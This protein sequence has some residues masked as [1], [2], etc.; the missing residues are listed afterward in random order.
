MVFTQQFRYDVIL[1]ESA[2]FSE[3]AAFVDRARAAGATAD[4]PVQAVPVAQDDSIIDYLSI[5]LDAHTA[6]SGGDAIV[7]VHINV[8]RQLRDLLDQ[9]RTSEGDAIAS[10]RSPGLTPSWRT[11]PTDTTSATTSIGTSRSSTGL[12]VAS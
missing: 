10:A 9:L 12:M 2:P 5:E 8:I 4:T 11:W 3:V 7:N 1:G 6:S